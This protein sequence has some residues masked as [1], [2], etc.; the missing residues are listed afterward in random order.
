MAHLDV[1]SCGGVAK[2]ESDLSTSITATPYPLVRPFIAGRWLD[3]LPAIGKVV[4]P[5]NGKFLAELPAVNADHI[6]EAVEAADKAFAVWRDMTAYDRSAILRKAAAGMRASADLIATILT[7]EQGKPHR[8]ARMEVLGAADEFDW[9]AEEGRRAYGRVIPSR[10]PAVRNLAVLEPVGPVALFTPW[11]FPAV[12]TGRKIASALSAGCSVLI[13][14]AEQTPATCLAMARCLEEAGLP[15]GTVNVLLGDPAA[16]SARLIGA[17]PVRKISF[18]GSTGVGRHIAKL[19]AESLKPAIMEL[20]GH[21]PVL[22]FADADVEKAARLSVLQKF[23]NAGQTC[24][25]PTRFYVEDRV[26]DRFV[27]LLAAGAQSI[28][29][30]DGLDSESQ[31]GPLINSRRVDV[32]E[33]LA[34]D[35]I[36]HGARP[37]ER[38]GR[39]EREGSYCRP[40]VLADVPSHAKVMTEEPF[41]PLAV[42]ARF[43]GVDEAIALANSLPLGLASYAFSASSQ[44]IRKVGTYIDAGMFGVNHF[45]LSLPETPF[46]GVRD[47]GYGSEGGMEGMHNFM[48]TKTLSEG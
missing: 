20:G 3:D 48:R 47:S 27:E 34:E 32:I 8:E 21:A 15:A 23:R 16:I 31:M 13:K 12:I 38:G 18:T 28:K 10:F 44:T 43:S 41:G 29:V 1:D 39:L 35:A 24:I 7:L 26:H 42:T 46:G 33:E 25:S 45:M 14:P 36:Q 22:V 40:I 30:G 17:K 11:N 2:L 19:C 37:I 9:S 6:D 5:A 4:N